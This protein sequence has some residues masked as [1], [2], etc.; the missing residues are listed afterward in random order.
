MQNKK[1][2][3]YIGNRL[4]KAN[5]LSIVDHIGGRL[6]E[7]YPMIL[8]SDKK[9][10]L[11]R[12]IDMMWTVYANRNKVGFVIIDVFSTLNFYYALAVSLVCRC[13]HIPYIPNL[14]G[15]NLPNRIHGNRRLC[16]AIFN[17]SFINVAPSNY[18][19]KNF[20][21]AGYNMKLIPNPVEF[22]SLIY[23][24]R[25][26]IKPHILYVRAFKEIYNPLMAV[27]MFKELVGAYPEARMTMYGPALDENF[28]KVKLLVNEYNLSDQI[29]LPGAVAKEEWH[30][31]AKNHDIFINTSKADNTPFSLIE[32]AGLGLPIVSSNVGGI[33]FLLKDDEEALLVN[34][35]DHLAM[36]VRIK[37]LLKNEKL[38]ERIT[39]NSYAKVKKFDWEQVKTLWIE[40]I[41]SVPYK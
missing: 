3:I 38:V 29:S 23:K 35:D 32:A 40:L 6:A 39:T 27:R 2:G 7:N 25:K 4:R 16:D 18:L 20:S 19:V 26:N 10:K 30:R 15:G 5:Y 11:L 21:E 41:E 33:P 12:L 34:S 28:D 14:H 22:D 13:C 36:A 9:N 8:I 17:N 37:S 24:P 31:D 1:K